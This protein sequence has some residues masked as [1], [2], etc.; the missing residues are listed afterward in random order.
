[1][2]VHSFSGSIETQSVRM[3]E[4]LRHANDE[5]ERTNGALEW[6]ATVRE[7]R[8]HFAK[9]IIQWKLATITCP[10]SVR[11]GVWCTMAAAR[12]AIESCVEQFMLAF[13]AT[14]IAR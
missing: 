7:V 3:A 8:E 4:S 10:S 9:L 1:M 13:S 12:N 14:R 5:D 2:H 6:L 11:V